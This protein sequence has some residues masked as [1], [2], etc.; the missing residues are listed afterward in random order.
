MNY[1]FFDLEYASC[2]D[3]DKK[4]CEFGYVV[5]DEQFAI[6]E[7]DNLIINPN[8][9]RADWDY[10]ALRDILTRTR[11][12]Y[13]R[14][15]KF[16]HF[17]DRIAELINTAD[18]VFGHTIDGDAVAV[19][20]NCARY[21]L[22]YINY[23]FYDVKEIY[24][25]FSN[26]EKSVGVSGILEE[27]GLSGLANSHDAMADAYNTMLILKGILDRTGKSLLE[28]LDENKNAKDK[29]EN[30]VLESIAIA[31]KFLKEH[32]TGDGSNLFYNE[33]NKKRYKQFVKEM[34]AHHR[35]RARLHNASIGISK[36]YL[37]NHYRQALNLTQLIFGAGGI[38][39][40]DESA[41][42][43]IYVTYDGVA[44]CEED[45]VLERVI[46]A[47]QNGAEI[48]I[49][50]FNELLDLLKITNEQLENMPMPSFEFLL[51]KRKRSHGKKKN[52]SKKEKQADFT[53]RVVYA[54]GDSG[55]SITE[56]LK[57]QGVAI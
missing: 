23:E 28:L 18:Y 20:Q 4:I 26:G 55:V 51:E 43:D 36:N 54:D 53:S 5:T 25:N 50:S 7:E 49:I 57:L 6:L 34:F 31:E 2:K 44:S 27:M 35:R 42:P 47:N 15:F 8:I 46:E 56:L 14:C 30:G 29:T 37:F 41:F 9:S 33:L 22:D 45:N 1:L 52:S 40:R 10:R 32:L 16:N 21:N 12:E 13:E 38:V 39:R 48:K 19:N 24:K 11:D 17:Y 3:G